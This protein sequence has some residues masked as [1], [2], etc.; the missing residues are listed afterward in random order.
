[1]ARLI[2]TEKEVEGRFTR[3]SGSSSRRTRSTSG[4]RGRSKVVGRPAARL[5]GLER[6]RGEAPYTA[7]LQPAGDAPHGR[8]AQPARARARAQ[9]RPRSRRSRAP[10]VRA[11]LGPDDADALD[12]RARLRRPAVAAV[13]AET[14]AQA[15]AAV[16][17]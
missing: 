1:M 10:G 12:R 11:V 4:P 17:G 7:D 14:F 9:H 2:R 3:R 8:A 13:G 16:D 6:A 5:D 15:R